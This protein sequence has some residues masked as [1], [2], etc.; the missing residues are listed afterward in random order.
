[1]S[2]VRLSDEDLI[3]F[4][5][6]LDAFVAAQRQAALTAAEP[7]KQRITLSRHIGDTGA[8]IDLV[9]EEGS[10]PEEVFAS[11]M[12][13]DK[14]L[15]RYKAKMDLA[16]WLGRLDDAVRLLDQALTKRTEML[17]EYRQV[18][19][20]RNDNRRNPILF[21]DAQSSSLKNQQTTID[22]LNEQ[23][24]GH[25]QKIVDCKRVLVEG[26]DEADVYE[27]RINERLD[28][29]RGSRPDAA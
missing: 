20:R 17:G 14:A 27:A 3:K 18:N 8:V 19:D 10:L 4:T 12:P 2:E 11:F 26:L 25:K 22:G 24:E 21:T 9:V 5:A 29:L 16:T 23:I 13:I 15:D 28:R 1:M 6:V 7:K